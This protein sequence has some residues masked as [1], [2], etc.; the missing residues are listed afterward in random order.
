MATE[1]T[2][3]ESARIMFRDEIDHVAQECQDLFRQYAVVGEGSGVA[4]AHRLAGEVEFNEV[5]GRLQPTIG[6]EAMLLHRYVRPKKVVGANLIDEDDHQT[7]A[8]AVAPQGWI[9]ESHRKGAKKKLNKIFLDGI[10]G[11]NYEGTEEEQA[12]VVIPDSQKVAADYGSDGN[13]GL[14]LAK[15]IR[16]VGLF[17]E[18]EVYGQNIDDDGGHLC[19]AVAQHELNNLL[20]DVEQIGSADY[21]DVKALVTG[22][23]HEFMGVKFLRTQ[24]VAKSGNIRSCPMWYSK[25]VYFDFW[26]DLMTSINIVAT[27]SNAILVRSKLKAGSARKEENAVVLV[28]CDE[29]V[30]LGA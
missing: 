13:S 8:T 25:G 2:I 22:R 19:M 20:H 3:P 6:E 12:P 15:L 5:T 17:G 11:T 30:P 28:A 16:A 10:V 29:S 7:L 26:Y 18:N 24:Q 9:V 1:F 23:V 14:T 4:T 21:N 27:Q